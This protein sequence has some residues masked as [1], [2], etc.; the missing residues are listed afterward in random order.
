MTIAEF[1][2]VP[3]FLLRPTP[4]PEWKGELLGDLVEYAQD[5]ESAL[6]EANADKAAVAAIVTRETGNKEEE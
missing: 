5:L 3:R 4:A 2:S 1:P 6:A